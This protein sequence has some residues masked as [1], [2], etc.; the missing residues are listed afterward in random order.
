MASSRIQQQL[1]HWYSRSYDGLLDLV[2]YQ[3]LLDLTTEA[4][5]CGPADRLVDLGCGTGNLLA[6]VAAAAGPG[7]RLVGV[8]SS[9]SMLGMARPKLVGTD[10]AELVESDLLAWLAAAPSGS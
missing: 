5:A 9:A 3:R 4:V 8:D 10:R 1:W 6:R 7:A 2:P